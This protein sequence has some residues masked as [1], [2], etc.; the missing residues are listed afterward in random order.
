[1]FRS[2]EIVLIPKQPAAKIDP[3]G[4]MALRRVRVAKTGRKA[5][6]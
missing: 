1:M 3:V 5:V 4:G 6:L 2:F